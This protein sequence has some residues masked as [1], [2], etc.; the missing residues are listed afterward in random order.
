METRR[1]SCWVQIVNVT[2]EFKLKEY[3]EMVQILKFK[4]YIVVF[5]YTI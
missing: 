3:Q 1:N 2:K 4:K 5:I